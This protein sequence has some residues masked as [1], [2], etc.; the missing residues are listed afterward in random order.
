MVAIPI[1][2]DVKDAS[3][4]INGLPISIVKKGE[5]YRYLGI[6]LSI[7]DLSKP[8]LVQA[9][10]DVKFFSNVVLK[11]AIMDK[12]FSYLVLA[13]LQL[14]VGYQIQFSFVSSDICHKWDVMIQ[15]GLKAKTA[16]PYN[17]PNETFR[18]KRCGDG[19]ENI[20]M[21][22]EARFK[23]LYSSLVHIGV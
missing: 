12:Q 5:S 21:V 1:N 15:K 20:L 17:F 19:L 14:I 22:E 2:Q 13:V 9:H 18:Q 6:F 23:R 8:S 10:K 3:L 7:E 4:L 11:K 16:L